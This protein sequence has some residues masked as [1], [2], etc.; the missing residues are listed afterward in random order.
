M[1]KKET[2][3]QANT[4]KLYIDI[5]RTSRSV[6]MVTPKREWVPVGFQRVSE[7][8]AQGPAELDHG[9]P[10]VL[11]GVEDAGVHAN[12]AVPGVFDEV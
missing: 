8:K 4:P 3:T 11:R 5:S 12:K 2:L 10:V 1:L 9:R 6:D 7:A